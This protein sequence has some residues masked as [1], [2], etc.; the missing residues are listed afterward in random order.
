MNRK[1]FYALSVISGTVI[2]VGIFSLPYITLKSGIWVMAGYFAIFGGIVIMVSYLFGRVCLISPDFLR[3]SGLAGIYLGKKGKVIAGFSTIFGLSGAILAY[4]IVGGEFLKELL[5]PFWGGDTIFYTF[6]Y[7]VAGAVLIYLG[8]K[9]ISKIEFLGLLL[10][11]LILGGIFFR[12]YFQSAIN[13]DNVFPVF[14][15]GNLFLPYGAVL[16][17]LWGAALIPEAEEMLGLNKKQLLK[18]IPFAILIPIA[19]YFVFIFLILGITGA[20]TTESALTGLKAFLGNGI[21]VLSLF[22]GL[23]TTFTSFLALGLTLKK[24]FMYDLG[25]GEKTAWAITCFPPL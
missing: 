23:V 2:G 25:V 8:I 13:L 15:P 19:V 5:I 7:F 4:L 3:L 24:V 16:F 14:N 21:V 6:L 22:F 11:F 9:A 10:F 1:S 18:I 17:S 12:A 20:Q